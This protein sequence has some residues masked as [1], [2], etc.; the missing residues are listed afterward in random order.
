[1]Y[2][3]PKNLLIINLAVAIE[4]FG[5]GFGFT[6]FTMVMIRAAEGEYK[7]V[8]YA[9]GTGLMALGMM[10]PAMSSG[11]LQEHLGYRL[12]FLWVVLST[13]PGFLVTAMIKID[14]NFGKR[15]QAGDP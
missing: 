7:T 2:A 13:I 14:P 5:Y 9:I 6:A 15:T 12:F 4:Q 8:H 1:A 11:W 3:L 10:L